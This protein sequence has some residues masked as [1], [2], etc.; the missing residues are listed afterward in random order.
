MLCDA[1]ISMLTVLAAVQRMD[2][3]RMLT[4]GRMLRCVCAF[5]NARLPRVLNILPAPSI[6]WLFVVQVHPI[7]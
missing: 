3:R 1:A 2:G 6:S 7:H 4:G 5:F